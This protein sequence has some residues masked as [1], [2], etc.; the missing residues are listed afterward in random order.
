MGILKHIPEQITDRVPKVY[1]SCHKDDFDLCF[2]AIKKEITK[3]R[4][5]AVFYDAD[6]DGERD[7]QFYF[8][9]SNMHLFVMP[10]TTRL[11][12]K[13][14]RALG[15]EL[16]FAI[17]HKIPVLPLMQESGL[18]ELYK[19]KFGDLQFLDKNSRELGAISYEEK[20]DKYLSSILLN[21]ETIKRIREE[22]DAQIFLSYRKKDRI[23]ANHLMRLIHKNDFC[24]DIAIWYDEFLTPGEN[25]NDN[26]RKAL[27][28]SGLFV[29]AVT[30]SLLEPRIDKEGIEHKNYIEE[31]EYPMAKERESEGKIAILPAEL[32]KTD[33]ILL[34]QKYENI[35]DC[36][37][38]DDENALTEALL[39]TAKKL[40]NDENDNSPEHNY[41][42]GLAYLN[43]IDVEVDHARAREMIEF[44]A[45]A[46]YLE[47]IDKMIEMYKDG[48]GTERN[49]E[50]AIQWH[51]RKITLLQKRYNENPNEYNAN[52]LFRALIYCG[53]EYKALGKPAEAIEKYTAAK[54]LCEAIDNPSNKTLRNRSVSYEKLGDIYFSERNTT[55]AKEYYEKALTIA[56]QLAAETNTVEARRD[57]SASYNKLGDIYRSEGDIAKAKEYYE[58]AFAIRE[59]LAAETNTAEARRD[60]SISYNS[61]GDIYRREGNMS[62]AKEYCEKSLAIAEQLAAETNT[63]EARRDLSVSYES[64][65]NIYIVE[66]NTAKANEYYEKAL[67][68]TE[69]LAEETNMV[70]ARRDLSI[71][72][73]KLGYIY[74]SEG[75]MA[76]AKEYYE[77]SLAIFEQLAAETNTV[78]ARRD[79]SKSHEILGDIYKSEGNTAKAKEYY[80]KALPIFEQLAKETNTVLARRD[81]SA[82]YE[83]LGDIYKSEGDMAKAK[84][85]YEK[86]LAIDEQL[87]AET[88]T[89]RARHDLAISYYNMSFVC[90]MSFVC[91]GEEKRGYLI[92]A[93]NIVNA[94]CEQCPDIA[95]YELQR[96]II[97]SELDWLD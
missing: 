82:S 8:D 46:D 63:V 95:I 80:E 1:F 50:T 65:G 3:G 47:A 54:D 30:P 22:F 35:P 13:P 69:Q 23:H 55:K 42:I 83:R 34:S 76:K 43:G 9:L 21:D 78:L 53:D 15:E 71:S 94:L 36:V 91:Q 17:E 81:L 58:K 52:S 51:E 32:V 33:S 14:N 26:I 19:Q 6:Y 5:C 62:K 97:Q 12:T 86:A 41:L 38:S 67:A 10:I 77:K 28:K 75:D 68:I 93:L 29:L 79:L 66:G 48:I 20:P 4:N 85:Y 74:E 90:H 40:V 39:N 24:R 2:E 45:N 18:E 11:L 7:E 49:Y 73:N 57:L 92:K 89:E 61:L 27:D 72:Y 37:D 16:D 25:F 31:H 70:E 84:E 64:L 44:A 60:L 56:E 59:Q 96:D 87:A 88:N